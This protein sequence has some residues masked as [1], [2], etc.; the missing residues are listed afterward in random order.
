MYGTCDF[1]DSYGGMPIPDI[2]IFIDKH[3]NFGCGYGG[4][5][6]GKLRGNRKQLQNYNS[7]VCGY[8]CI[9]F[10]SKRI[11][12]RD[13]LKNYWLFVMKKLNWKTI[14][15]YMI[16]LLIHVLHK[17]K[18]LSFLLSIMSI[19]KSVHTIILSSKAVS[20]SIICSHALIEWF[21]DAIANRDCVVGFEFSEQSNSS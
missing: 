11:T 7:D 14:N 6:C 1:F 13:L 10:S 19:W 17:K 18:K 12:E 16:I 15:L 4:I 3:T 2:R 5:A 21:F 9:Y 20:S 8:Y